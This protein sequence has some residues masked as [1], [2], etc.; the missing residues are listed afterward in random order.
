MLLKRSVGY[1]RI[2]HEACQTV[3]QQIKYLCCTNTAVLS[4][5]PDSVSDTGKGFLFQQHTSVEGN[6]WV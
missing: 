3:N 6:I 1:V 5:F 4:S 2:L